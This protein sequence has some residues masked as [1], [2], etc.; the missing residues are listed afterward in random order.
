[1]PK[2]GM[3]EIRRE[4]V[5]AATTRCI[6]KK[7]MAGLSIKDI[8]AEAGIST[9]IIYHYFKNKEEILLHVIRAAFQQS[10]QAV[11]E[12]VEP[13]K[14]PR[15]KLLRHIENI[16]DVPKT[17]SAFYALLLNYLG[18]TG[19]NEQVNTIIRK[20]FKNLR[21]YVRT[22]LMQDVDDKAFPTDRTEHLA[23]IVIALGMG[24]GIMWTVD[25]D[26]FNLDEIGETYKEV[27]RKFVES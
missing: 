26:A 16:N 8:A 7:G 20:F 6:V 24:L 11:M 5:I 10:H 13:L 21:S 15:D 3:E 19:S 22:Y 9:G 4:Q 27:I 12:T 14:S 2:L 1:M 25:P 18:Q 23:A 17:N